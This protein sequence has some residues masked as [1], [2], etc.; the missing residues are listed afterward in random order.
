M[1][2]IRDLLHRRPGELSGGEQQRVALG[3]AMIREPKVFLLDEPLSNLD[4]KLRVQMRGEIV[5][6]HRLIGTTMIY[7]TH[8]QVEAMTMGDRIAV[9][10][11]GELQQID[12]P[13]ALYRT[14]VNP[15]VG[16]FTGN[17]SMNF[18][19]PCASLSTLFD[20]AG[21]HTMLGVRPEHIGLEPCEGC[22][23]LTVEA[24]LVEMLGSDTLVHGVFEQQKLIVRIPQMSSIAVGD[25][26]TVYLDPERILWF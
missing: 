12:T 21:A 2:G 20:R 11:H 6:L 23:P 1:L 18:I 9:L 14:P 7:V 15:F 26:L 17:Y 3:R 10:N 5:R 22:A 25:F 16:A 4:P 19:R 13:V 24:E 8:D